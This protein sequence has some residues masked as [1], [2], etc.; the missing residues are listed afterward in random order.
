MEPSAIENTAA[1]QVATVF[2]LRADGAALLQHRED[3]PGLRRSSMWVP[4]GGG[5]DPGES[6]EAGARREIREETDY[7]CGDLR[8]L[9][10]VEDDPGD[11]GPIECLHV[12]WTIYDGAQA[13]RCLE[14]QDLRFVPRAGAGGYRMPGFLFN[15]WDRALAAGSIVPDRPAAPATTKETSLTPDLTTPARPGPPQGARPF[16]ARAQRKRCIKLRKRI[17]EMSQTVSALHI[18]GAYS[19][20][21][22]VATVYF[23]LMRHAPAVE[24]PDTFILSKG[25]GSLAQYTALEE[26]GVLSRAEMDKY[27]KPG[28]HLGTH[29]DVGLPG[30]EASTGSLGH[31]LGIAMGMAYAD[32]VRGDDRVV[33]VVMS[34]GELQEGSVWEAMML[35]PTLGLNRVVAFVDLNGFQSLGRTA[36]SHPN[37]FPVLEKVRAFGWESV[38]IDGHDPQAVYDAVVN[39][40]GDRPFMAVARTVKGKGVSYMENVPIWHYRSPNPQE[41]Q[42]ALRELSEWEATL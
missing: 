23:G 20:L 8:W 15:L 1:R 37:F 24:K 4:P 14:G 22:I 40:R 34:D 7:V 11:G 13:P 9:E 35:A 17:L 31:G 6:P 29:P 26:L 41:Y 38:E 42:Q 28:G 2:I 12:F 25:H 27:C 39:R 3:K 10:T 16:D 36:E 30:I 21:E 32:K 18:A 33:Y 19:C 5:L